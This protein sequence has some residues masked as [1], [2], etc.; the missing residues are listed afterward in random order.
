M[1]PNELNQ[2]VEEKLRALYHLQNIDSKI[3]EI[4]I[5]R[6]E[7]P[8]EVQDLEDELEGLNTR[9]R[10]LEKEMSELHEKIANHQKNIGNAEALI[11]KYTKQQDNVKNNREFEALAKEIELQKLEIELSNKR[12]REFGRDAESKQRFLEE[13]QRRAD[14]KK[15]DL[16]VKRRELQQIIEET[17]REEA[18]LTK[19]SNKA[20]EGIEERLLTAYQRI[21]K[22]YRNGLAVV[23]VDRDSCGG[24]FGKIPPQRQMEIRQHKKLIL[25]E[26]CGR[27]LVDANIDEPVTAV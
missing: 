7:L 16:E 6:G 20:S 27:I 10:N 25:C 4:R 14:S 9:I 23:T 12:I 3:D 2:T 17:G 15:R 11:G 13:A 21:R 19:E 1:T 24:C 22:N 5:L 8:I 26:H 18:E